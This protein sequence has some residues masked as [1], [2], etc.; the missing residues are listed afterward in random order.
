[1]GMR[2][3]CHRSPV[4]CHTAAHV[5]RTFGKTWGGDSSLS[6]WVALNLFHIQAFSRHSYSGQFSMIQQCKRLAKMHQS[7]PLPLQ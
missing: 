2:E 1:M 3:P 6:P 4:L 7:N 5:M